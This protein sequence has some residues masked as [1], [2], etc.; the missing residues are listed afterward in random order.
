MA[1][2]CLEALSLSYL[3]KAPKMKS[4]S[5]ER[6]GKRIKRV[7]REYTQFPKRYQKGG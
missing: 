6:T 5:Q 1:K 2:K 3:V 7:R 4:E